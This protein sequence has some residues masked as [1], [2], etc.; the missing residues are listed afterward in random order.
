[1]DIGG[2]ICIHS[3]AMQSRTR[4]QIVFKKFLIPCIVSEIG[5]DKHMLNIHV[6]IVR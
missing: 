6:L 3:I 1:M 4:L 2:N 5:F